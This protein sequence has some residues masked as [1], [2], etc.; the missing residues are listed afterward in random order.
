VG[1]WGDGGLGESRM[2]V[3]FHQ[4]VLD[5]AEYGQT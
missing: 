2:L 3:Y 5:C 4:G 1:R